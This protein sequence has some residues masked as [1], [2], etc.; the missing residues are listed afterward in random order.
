MWQISNVIGY[1]HRWY[2]RTA[3]LHMSQNFIPT[4]S[5]KQP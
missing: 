2:S 1:N 5:L 3:I 4:L